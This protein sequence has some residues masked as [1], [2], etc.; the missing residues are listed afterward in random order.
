MGLKCHLYPWTA[1][2]DN[3]H[4]FALW[5]LYWMLQS[6]YGMQKDTLDP[7]GDNQVKL[8]TPPGG[9]SQW[10]SQTVAQREGKCRAPANNQ[11]YIHDNSPG[12][13]YLKGQTAEHSKSR[14]YNPPD[15]KN[16]IHT[17]VLRTSY[18]IIRLE[19]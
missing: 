1:F 10:Q 14:A 13:T 12:D 7:Y 2:W 9:Y 18:Y 15:Y 16:I 11:F 5:C 6:L 17:Y 4:I 3:A 19:Y 8:P